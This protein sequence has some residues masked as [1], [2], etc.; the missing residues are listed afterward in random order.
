M[1]IIC[2]LHPLKLGLFFAD[3]LFLLHLFYFVSHDNKGTNHFML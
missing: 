1:G 2:E 3:H